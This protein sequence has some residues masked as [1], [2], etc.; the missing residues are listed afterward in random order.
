MIT[1][2][3]GGPG[4]LLL[5]A[6]LGR[7][8]VACEV[9]EADDSP[10]SRHQGGML[11]LNE[12]T[13]LRAIE[14]AGLSDALKRR[15][16]VGGDGVRVRGRDGAVRFE[17]PGDGRR[18]EI[19]RGGLR[20]LLLD[21]LDPGVVRWGRRVAGVSRDGD[22]FA[23]RFADGAE[24]RAQTL[25]GADGA[26]SRA[27][28]LLTAERPSYCGVTFVE[29]RYLHADRAHP[30]V[31]A[32]IGDGLF[33]A[34]D[35]ERGVM[36]HREPDHELCVYAAAKVPEGWGRGGVTR[37]ELVALFEGWHP[38]FLRALAQSDGELVARPLYALPVGHRWA[39]SQGVTLLGDAAHVMSPFAGEGVNLALTD[40]ADLADAL[41][42]H[43]ADREAALA[44]YEATMF[45][46]AAE[47]AAESAANLEVAFSPGGGERFVEMFRALHAQ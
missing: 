18:P 3:G 45:A 5:A 27:R 29:L 46:R 44:D 24:H 7:R 21:A 10:T 14:R 15:V 37:A 33:F 31:L 35:D 36:G 23:L 41:L 28:P 12:G 47:S 38:M 32:M 40:A 17:H 19:D 13:G 30:E 6:I 20:A 8:G 43:P 2:L 42:A 34:L 39:R 11:N 16:L 25:V 4:G 1:I 26:W 22:G 9:F